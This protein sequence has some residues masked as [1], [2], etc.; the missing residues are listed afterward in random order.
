MKKSLILKGFTFILLLVCN[1]GFSQDNRIKIYEKKLVKN[2]GK[3]VDSG[4]CLV[5]FPGEQQPLMVMVANDKVW[6]VDA[7]PP[8]G[9]VEI[10]EKTLV[11]VQ[12][13]ESPTLQTAKSR[14]AS[15]GM[16][17]DKRESATGQATGKRQHKPMLLSNLTLDVLD[18]D[19]DDDG[20]EICSF[21]WGVSNHTSMSNS[22]SSGKLGSSNCC[23]NG[24]C[25]VTVSIDKRKNKTGHVTLMK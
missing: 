5:V 25:S 7:M 15:S 2:E 16:A 8:D 13:R 6:T 21:S 20:I 10:P 9:W 3:T 19:S 14:E 22:A 11:T 12:F 18:G 1:V 23:S 24:V 4:G 17:S